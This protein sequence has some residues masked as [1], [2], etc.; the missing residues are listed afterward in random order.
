MLKSTPHLH[1]YEKG[2]REHFT[3]H[4]LFHFFC[5]AGL[6]SRQA[7]IQRSAESLL[8]QLP[9]LLRTVF[10]SLSLSLS[11]SLRS[12]AHTSALHSQR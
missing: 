10:C 7:D 11:L 4:L 2:G 12:G 6:S 1:Y 8:H 5:S 9:A 3:L